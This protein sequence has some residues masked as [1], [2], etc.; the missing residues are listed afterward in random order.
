ML[1]SEAPLW[2]IRRDRESGA[3]VMDGDDSKLLPTIEKMD[4]AGE[5]GKARSFGT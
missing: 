4:Q 1:I 3:A 5:R 2:E